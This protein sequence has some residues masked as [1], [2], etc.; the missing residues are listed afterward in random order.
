[1]KI[2]LRHILCFCLLISAPAKGEETDQR[3]F[4]LQ[5]KLVRLSEQSQKFEVEL[6]DVKKQLG[7]LDNI[8]HQKTSNLVQKEAEI[9][10]FIR[11]MHRISIGGPSSFLHKN[12][13]PEKWIRSVL[14]LNSIVRS[15]NLSCQDLKGQIDELNRLKYLINDKKKNIDQLKG[16]FKKKY[17][18]IEGLLIQR[19][20]M[21]Q[22]ELKRRRRVEQRIKRFA[23]RSKSLHDLIEQIYNEEMEKAR[24]NQGDFEKVVLK[25]THYKHLPVQG[26]VI[27]NFGKK[28]PRD[29]FGSGLLFKADIGSHVSSPVDGQVLFSGPFRG[30]NNIIIIGHDQNYHTVII[31]VDRI[32]VSTGQVVLA[33]EPIGRMSIEKEEPLYMELRHKG[34]P[35]DPSKWL[36]K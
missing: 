31:G 1:M 11:L 13:S 36:K 14:V 15:M 16:K 25:N 19:R 18:E 5:K 24:R 6:S 28:H 10:A 3:C 29:P 9:A 17:N 2:L 7:N 4:N 22:Q 12:S 21:I 8:Q 26:P 35:M 34:K 23:K 32:D 33:G 20:K 27:S 30:Y